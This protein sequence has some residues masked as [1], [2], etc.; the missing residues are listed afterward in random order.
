MINVITNLTDFKC[1]RLIDAAF[2]WNL[3]RKH[4]V[5]DFPPL[6]AGGCPGSGIA[7][8]AAHVQGLER[9]EPAQRALASVSR[10]AQS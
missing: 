4:K 3:N 7:V 10:A 1:K 6:S 9:E 8:L 5:E 2:I